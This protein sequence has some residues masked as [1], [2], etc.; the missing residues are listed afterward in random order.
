MMWPTAEN[1]YEEGIRYSSDRSIRF[2]WDWGHSDFIV[3]TLRNGRWETVD[4]LGKAWGLSL[5]SSVVEL[6]AAWA[7]FLVI[8]PGVKR[9][10]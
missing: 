5:D 9:S 6:E 10:I 2:E 1:E 4:V 3:T 8:N 7:E